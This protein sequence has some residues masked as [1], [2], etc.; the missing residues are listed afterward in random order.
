MK[1]IVFILMIFGLFVA[2]A[3]S[4]LPQTKK[5]YSLSPIYDNGTSAQTMATFN[6]TYLDTLKTTSTA[7]TVFYKLLINHVSIGYP[8]I[9][10]NTKLVSA[11]YDTT[12]VVTF[13]QSVD[14]KN[15]WVQIKQAYN[16]ILYDTTAI[17]GT[18]NSNTFLY[19]TTKILGGSTNVTRFDTTA[20]A[21]SNIGA[22]EVKAL[23]KRA[24]TTKDPV[25]Y[26]ASAG[27]KIQALYSA[28]NVATETAYSVTLAKATTKGTDISF[29]RN[30]VKFES[31]YL[32]IQIIAP[33][34]TSHKTIYY[35]TIRF[36]KAY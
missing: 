16:S 13:W 15:N 6:A 2:N 20:W 27:T 29:W 12:A 9:S 19:D 8:Y 3:F 5:I 14:G 17:Y 1:K 7:D 23:Y 11:G 35:G 24:T 31:Q 21:K 18:K 30:N 4:Q 33:A 34:R 32:G 25:P 26:T 36:Q 10:I 22:T 28:K